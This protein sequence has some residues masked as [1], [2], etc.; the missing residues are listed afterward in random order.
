[1][2]RIS[3]RKLTALHVAAKFGH[4]TVVRLSLEHGANIKETAREEY[5]ALHL[6]AR[7]GHG[8]AVRLLLNLG[9]N[10]NEKD[11]ERIHGAASGG[12][13]QTQDDDSAV[14]EA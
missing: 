11:G 14:A 13:V 2:E 6:A 7:S 8:A 12:R 1:M 9:A 10:I 4:E 3:I 5:T